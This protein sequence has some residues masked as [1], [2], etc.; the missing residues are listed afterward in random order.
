MPRRLRGLVGNR[1]VGH[2]EVGLLEEPLAIDQQVEV[3]APG[4]RL[5]AKRRL[6]HRPDD[7]PDLAPSIRRRSGPSTSGAWRR[8]SA[9][10]RRCRAARTRGPHQSSIG[11]RLRSNRPTIV[12]SACDQPVDRTERRLRPVDRAHESAHLAPVGQHVGGTH[13]VRQHLGIARAEIKASCK[14]FPGSGRKVAKFNDR[15]A[16]RRGRA[17]AGDLASLG[18]GASSIGGRRID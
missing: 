14:D 6:D 15:N 13:I 11:K 9:G 18:S 1:A 16:P 2:L 7:V 17:H 3:V 10:T 12:R 4:R 8:G 5:A